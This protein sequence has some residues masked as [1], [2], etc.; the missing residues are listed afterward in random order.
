MK[1]NEQYT[2]ENHIIKFLKERLD[3]EYIVPQ[4]FSKFREFENEYIIVPIL[5][6]VVKKIN[7]I[8]DSE[9][10]SVVREVKK[11]DSNEAFLKA[12][13]YGINLKDPQTGKM[14]DYALIDFNNQSNNRFIITNQFYF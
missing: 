13:R 14:R 6:D 7:N 5:L 12:L 10:L 11:L 2:I 9:A 8:D 4:E 3:F 1:F